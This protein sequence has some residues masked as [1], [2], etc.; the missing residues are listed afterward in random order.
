MASR[1]RHP[2]R[3]SSQLGSPGIAGEGEGAPPLVGAP[4]SQRHADV[5][6]EAARRR[7]PAVH[8]QMPAVREEQEFIRRYVSQVLRGRDG[9]YSSRD[10]IAAPDTFPCPTCCD[11]SAG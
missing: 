2:L 5:A 10:A 8:E 1:L 4:Q 9:P 3:P 11:L 6:L 7:P